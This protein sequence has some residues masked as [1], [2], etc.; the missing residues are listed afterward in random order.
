MGVS[1]AKRVEILKSFDVRTISVETAG[2]NTYGIRF[3]G[4]NA[5]PM[6]QFLTDT[7]TPLTNRA[8]MALHYEWNTMTGIRQWQVVPGT[9]IFRGTVAPQL[10]Y[11]SQYIG[12]AKQ[13]FVLEP[14][15]YGTLQ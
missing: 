1:R 6:G 12:G 10:N 3:Y 4:E 2:S 11:G 5:R 8:N 15:N 13:I 9:T 14:W 7:F